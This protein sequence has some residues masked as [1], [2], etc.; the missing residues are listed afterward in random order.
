MVCSVTHTFRW[1]WCCC[2]PPHTQRHFVDN[3][4]LWQEEGTTTRP[5]LVMVVGGGGGV[6][7][8]GVGGGGRAEQK[9]RRWAP[10]EGNVQKL[11]CHPYLAIRQACL[12]CA[13]FFVPPE[14]NYKGKDLSAGHWQ[15]K[16]RRRRWWFMA[17]LPNHSEEVCS[18]R[19]MP[20]RALS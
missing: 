14:R 6:R 4:L 19:K 7:R 11:F 9:G 16:S 20:L 10:G 3:T 18:S 17:S 5:V 8:C 1:L 13:Q 15:E 2:P 12:H